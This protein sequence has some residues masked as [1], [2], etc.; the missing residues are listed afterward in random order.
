MPAE[1]ERK[2]DLLRRWNLAATCNSGGAEKWLAAF[3]EHFCGADVVLL[4]DNDAWPQ[5]RRDSCRVSHGGQSQ[6]ARA[7]PAG[8]RPQG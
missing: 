6:R 8:A 5:A 3:S 7:R 1:G 4:P 2:V